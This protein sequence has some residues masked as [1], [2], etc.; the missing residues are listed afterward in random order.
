[1]AKIQV[2]FGCG[3][4]GNSGVIAVEEELFEPNPVMGLGHVRCPTCMRRAVAV[5]VEMTVPARDDDVQAV[6]EAW[7]EVRRLVLRLVGN[8]GNL[9][10]TIT[11]TKLRAF[12]ES[13][14][15]DV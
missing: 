5:R 11:I 14:P 3:E 12:V 1:M 7:P 9:Y 13:L 6:L 2:R 4:C 10:S 8:E 15:K